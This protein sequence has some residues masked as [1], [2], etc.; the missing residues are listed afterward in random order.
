MHHVR[1]LPQP[2]PTFSDFLFLRNLSST[3]LMTFEVLYDPFPSY[4]STLLSH[5]ALDTSGHGSPHARPSALPG[6]RAGSSV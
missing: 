4:L 2:P 6:L 3:L 5:Y 1:P